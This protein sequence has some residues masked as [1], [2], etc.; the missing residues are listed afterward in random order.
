MANAER[1]IEKAFFEMNKEE[2]DAFLFAAFLTPILPYVYLDKKKK[3]QPCFKYILSE[4][5]MKG[6]VRSKKRK[7]HCC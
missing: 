4:S 5:C 6:Q 7:Q 3:P 1:L 2:K